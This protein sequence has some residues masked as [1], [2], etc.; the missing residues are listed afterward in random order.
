MHI[1]YSLVST[2]LSFHPT[3]PISFIEDTGKTYHEGDSG[4]QAKKDRLI[5]EAVEHCPR[6]WGTESTKD[7]SLVPTGLV[8]PPWT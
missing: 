7:S 2:R 3:G 8:R 1:L 5:V 4:L 6:G